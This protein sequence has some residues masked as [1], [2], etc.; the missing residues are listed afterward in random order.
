MDVFGSTWKD[1][2]AQMRQNWLDA[3]DDDDIVCIPGD[4]SWAMTLDEAVDDLSWIASLP[5]KKIMIRGNHDYWWNGISKV[6]KLLGE[7]MFALQNDCVVIDGLCFA[8]TRGWLLPS[9]PSFHG[10]EDERILQRELHRLELSL[11]EAAKTELPIV[12]MTH[13]PP[14]ENQ[15]SKTVFQTTL[16]QYGVKLCLY[17]HLHGPS[18]RFAV[19]D[20]VGGT[21]Y[22]LVSSDF[23]GFKPLRIP[24]A[25]LT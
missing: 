18:H 4:I 21:V 10:A 11:Q 23:L 22:Q 25:W 9:H 13:Y 15:V 7:G 20:L 8:G 12:C 2:A 1:H 17:G 16:E 14:I 3:I 5:G 24:D 19:N 6:R